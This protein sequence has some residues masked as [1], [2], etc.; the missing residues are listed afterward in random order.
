MAQNIPKSIIVVGSMNMDLVVQAPHLPAPGETLLGSQFQTFPGGKGANQAVA[1]TR[2][3]ARVHM[4]ARVGEDGFGQALID[5]LRADGVDTTYITKD[6]NAPTGTALITLDQA[7]EN[8]IVVVPGANSCLS[9]KDVLAAESIFEGARLLLLQLEIPLATV[10][11]AIELAH[12]HGLQVILNPAPA[13]DLE[14][15]LLRTVDYLIPNE[16]EL[17]RLTGM[18]DFQTA[19][20][21][22]HDLGVANLVVTLGGDG[23]YLVYDSHKIHLPAYPVAVVDTVAAGD[24][25]VGGFAAALIE[26][27]S[28]LSA[29]SF[30]N[31]SAALAVTRKGAQPSLPTHDEVVA[32]LV[33]HTTR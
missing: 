32:F 24:A 12:K 18:E 7:G 29:T 31:A 28:I 25:F 6:P 4:I 22:L 26:G 13:I 23:V 2:L 8:T 16:T 5:N 1:A 21:L 3:G 10:K 14:A 17:Q 27:Q 11:Q 19:A 20:D 30:G 15:E 9:P 33:E